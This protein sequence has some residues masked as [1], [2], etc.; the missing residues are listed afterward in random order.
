VPLPEDALDEAISS[1]DEFAGSP[2]D[3]DE[4]T[5]KLETAKE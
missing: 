2:P 5:S 4:V 3:L 1:L